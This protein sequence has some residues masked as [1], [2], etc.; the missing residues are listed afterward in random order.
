MGRNKEMPGHTYDLK[1][2]DD[3]E[4]TVKCTY[5]TELGYPSLGVEDLCWYF[6]KN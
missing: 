1:Y 4:V 6:L 5:L 3:N 2:K